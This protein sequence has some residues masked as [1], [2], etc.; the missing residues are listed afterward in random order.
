MCFVVP[1]LNAMVCFTCD[2]AC[3]VVWCV[4]CDVLFILCGVCACCF[5][6]MC[7]G[8]VIVMYWFGFV[9][10]LFLCVCSLF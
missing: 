9:C 8:V 7:L 3:V 5:S 1:V 10:G 2:L 4:V 6:S